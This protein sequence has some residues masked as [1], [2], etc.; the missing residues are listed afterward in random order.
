MAR[1]LWGVGFGVCFLLSVAAEDAPKVAGVLSEQV[2][3]SLEKALEGRAQRGWPEGVPA[4]EGGAVR[5][6]LGAVD[7][8]LRKDD[9]LRDRLR[10]ALEKA[11]LSEAEGDAPALE[12][13]AYL[14]AGG[15]T[16]WVRDPERG[17]VLLVV[18]AQAASSSDSIGG[19]VK[20][21]V[22]KLSRQA[23]RGWPPHVLLGG[24]G[25]AVARLSSFSGPEDPVDARLQL[26]EALVASE[27]LDVRDSTGAD[28]AEPPSLLL[29]GELVRDGDDRTVSLL[30][31]DVVKK[32]VIVRSTTLTRTIR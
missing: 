7:D 23:A 6:R 19:A 1:Q 15:A 4:S 25:K 10:A 22:Q 26:L 9:A 16:A 30:A 5:L 2:G 29:R 20:D 21:F 18:R 11:R 8:G 24:D 14:C 13:S 3:K 31:F 17:R 32:R 28:P 12:L 27:V